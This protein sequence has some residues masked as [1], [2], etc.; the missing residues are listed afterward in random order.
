MPYPTLLERFLRYV[1][2][3]TQSSDQSESFPST[4]KQRDLALVLVEELLELGLKD[5]AVNPW[6]Y[7]LATLETNQRKKA[8]VIALIGHLDTSPDVSGAE[9]QPAHP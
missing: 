8:P 9:R 7:V 4:A 1:K 3:D 6:G 5:A 2:I